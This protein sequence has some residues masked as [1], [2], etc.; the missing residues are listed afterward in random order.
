[1]LAA[2]FLSRPKPNTYSIDL[3]SSLPAGE[4]GGAAAAAPTPQPPVTKPVPTPVP[5]PKAEPKA[6]P[7]EAIKL[8]QKLKKVTAPPKP[9]VKPLP[10]QPPTKTFKAP[11][12]ISDMDEPPAPVTGTGGV[13]T[14]GKSGLGGSGITS[15]TGTPFPYPWYMSALS[16]KIDSNWSTENFEPG[17]TCMVYFVVQRDGSVST[18]RVEKRSGD[19]AFDEAASRAVTYAAPFPPLPGGYPESQLEVHMTF[20]G[21]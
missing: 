21:K 7:K 2:T 1:M 17:T 20:T 15:R 19:P 18:T 14:P 12:R 13:G 8:P 5:T 16:K 11:K 9:A 4:V 3:L 10:P 6:P